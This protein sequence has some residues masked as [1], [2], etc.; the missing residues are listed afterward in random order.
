MIFVKEDDDT[1][2]SRALQQT[3][4]QRKF[5]VCYDLMSGS[6]RGSGSNISYDPM[7]IDTEILRK[8]FTAALTQILNLSSFTFMNSE[9]WVGFF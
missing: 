5:F 9:G 8:L 3:F 4:C 1:L 2:F 7:T 6:V